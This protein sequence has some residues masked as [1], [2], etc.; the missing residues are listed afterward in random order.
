MAQANE[1]NKVKVIFDQA[2][3][4]NLET[5]RGGVK[6]NLDFYKGK[7]REM[8]QLN[9]NAPV[10]FDGFNEFKMKGIN[11]SIFLVDRDDVQDDLIQDYIDGQN[12]S[13]ENVTSAEVW[14][15]SGRVTEL[16]LAVAL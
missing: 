10:T 9:A 1:I 13:H 16:T 4:G 14:H 15:P 3:E 12:P 2:Y 6:A 8:F 7:A 11:R 5:F